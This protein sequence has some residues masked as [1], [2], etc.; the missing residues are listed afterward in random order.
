MPIRTGRPDKPI[1]TGRLS[2]RY[3]RRVNKDWCSMGRICAWLFSALL[4]AGCAPTA[5]L[6]VAL[7]LRPD[8]ES[9]YRARILRPFEKKHHCVVELKSY[10]DPALLPDLLA[11]G[12]SIDLADPPL[13]MTRGLV[14]RNL[15][16]PLDEF[17]PAK[18]LADLRKE[19]FLMDL[20]AVRGQTFFLPR[21]LETPVLLYL[22]SQVAEAV[23]YWELRKDEIDRA[24]AKY[25]G[26]GLP[27]NYVL[28]KD[29]SQWD[30]F[31]LFVAGYFWSNK[32]V[33]GQ[34]RGRIALGPTG[35]PALPQILADKCFQAGAGQDALLRMGDD[36]VV[37][38]FQWQAVLVREGILNPGLIKSSWSDTQIREGF[39]SGELFL[40]EA[41]QMEAFLIHGNG[42]P[43]MPG[44]LSNPGDM[45]VAL[46]PKGISMLLDQRGAP[47]REGRH[48]VGT[49]GQWLGVTRK[50]RNRELSWQLAHYLSGTQNQIL[51]SSAY[52][53]IPVRQDLLGELGLMFGGGWTSDLFQ[54][55]SQQLVE[56]RF[57]LAPMV[58]EFSEI[59]GN[60]ADA[61]REICLP[62][63]GQKT[64][65]ED[66]QKTLEDRFIPRQRQILGAKYPERAV[67]KR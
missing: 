48:S 53:S 62:G 66:I 58:E 13:A 34:R 57:T 63:D 31:D 23:Q 59:G 38:M 55:A 41:T 30:Y 15:I 35:S 21:Y 28:E 25:N 16:A 42:T 24:L 10:Q 50:S 37:D 26:K 9:W 19:Y 7:N 56:N 8:Q 6:K 39:R 51:E 1:W 67:S 14:A 49:R 11:S 64:R 60:Y 27:R 22:K 33:Q 46:M 45:G 52:G 32:E 44:F 20:G 12:D 65:F 43:E 29:P 2:P 61:Y 40:S 5:R 54:T 47:L 4:A 17:V 36:A 18:D 3:N